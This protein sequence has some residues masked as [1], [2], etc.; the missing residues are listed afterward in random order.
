MAK[1]K[2]AGIG[3]KAKFFDD[4][5][6]ENTIHYICDP[7]K[8][9]YT[10][11]SGVSSIQAAADEMQQVAKHFGKDCGK[12]VRHS[13]LGFDPTEQVTPEMADAFA[14]RIIQHYADQY[15]IV[16]G[17]HTDTD[18]THIHFLMNQVSF[19]DGHRYLG[20]RK[21]YHQFLSH[22]RKV[23]HLPVLPAR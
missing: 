20:K 13:I 19:T 12:R 14:Q 6:Y 7:R 15:Q 22:I 21:D 2:V 10:G 4:R 18:V 5:A 16:Y 17:V 23:T 9:K 3:E 11:G 1:Y 8:A